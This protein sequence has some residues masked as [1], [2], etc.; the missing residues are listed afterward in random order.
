M[1]IEPAISAAFIGAVA[2]LVAAV[3]ALIPYLG[4]LHRLERVVNILEKL[5]NEA[6]RMTL[7][8]L[9]ER[10][11]QRLRPR[12][13]Y[14]PLPLGHVFAVFFFLLAAMLIGI[15]VAQR[16]VW[17]GTGPAPFSGPLIVAGVVSMLL[18]LVNFIYALLQ[19]RRRRRA[20][21]WMRTMRRYYDPVNPRPKPRKKS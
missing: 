9:R 18:G 4:V 19:G 17:A 8:V 3:V 2:L 13:F 11:I 7:I 14:G 5:D 21:E 20:R 6:D 15:G 16:T 1:S 10:L 12:G